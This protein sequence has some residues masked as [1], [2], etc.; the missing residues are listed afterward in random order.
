MIPVIHFKKKNK[1]PCYV[2]VYREVD[3]IKKS[4]DFFCSLSNDLEIIVIENPSENTP[5]ISQY[6]NYLGNQGKIA[7]YY[8]FEKN[9]S[10]N[11]YDV[12]L[13]HHLEQIKN[14]QHIIVSDGDVTV[15]NGKQWLHEAE[16][17]MKNEQV[18]CCGAELETVNLPVESFPEATNWVPPLI[19]KGRV[20]E[21][22]TGCH[23]LMLRGNELG[24]FME[25]KK[26]ND[27]HFVDGEL[28][29]FCYQTLKKKWVRTKRNLAY[30]L[31]WDLYKDLNNSYT[32]LKTTKSFK[33]TWYHKNI[34]DFT[35]VEYK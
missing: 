23:L 29:K 6:I 14:H 33:D 1:I 21:G 9:I 10:N 12:I 11:A 26:E 30:H 3:I 25:W 35:V 32:K 5:I 31:T 4:L 22:L 7:S 24:L 19:S 28:H 18:F 27:N 17:I 8:L 34:S 16:R 20:N 15:K 2:L 13:T